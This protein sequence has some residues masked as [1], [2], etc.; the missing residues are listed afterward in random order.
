M[1]A[2]RF[3][4]PGE[5]GMERVIAESGRAFTE[6]GHRVTVL[7]SALE[8]DGAGEFDVGGLRVIRHAPAP[9]GP[10]KTLCRTGLTVRIA[11]EHFRRLAGET[12]LVIAKH[13]WYAA[14]AAGALDAPI[15]FAPEVLSSAMMRAHRRRAA[16][17]WRERL[18]F[19]CRATA[20]RRTER[21]ALA[22]ARAVVQPTEITRQ[23]WIDTYGDAAAN[24][25]VIPNGVD[26]RLFCPGGP[27]ASLRRELGLS[28]GDRMILLAARLTDE[29]DP[30]FL[31]EALAEVREKRA[32]LVIAGDGYLAGAIRRRAAE[33]HLAD[34]VILAG[35]R[36]DIVRFY[37]T[38]D[39]LVLPSRYEAFGNVQLEAMACGLPVVARASG[40]DVRT[41]A[42]EIVAHGVT[43]L[44]TDAHDPKH[45]AAAIDMIL[46][47]RA[48][49]ATMRTAARTRALRLFSWPDHVRRMLAA[50]GM[51]TAAPA[52]PALAWHAA[53]RPAARNATPQQGGIH[54]P[55]HATIP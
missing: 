39:L 34:R 22:V 35:M 41:P 14:A 28:A 24:I 1:I 12:D 4:Y 49:A 13:P 46:S 37:R 17:C 48:L 19:A 11:A 21:I 52:G 36:A 26:H 7:C 3:F 10:V 40:G 5:G 47:D 20:T 25:R 42:A 38:A 44:C 6:A 51:E 33:L 31:L 8:A 54:D 43:G 55:A 2:Y 30:M 32:K 29:K 50:V 53:E 27:D 18:A 45:M 9:F 23:E 16:R 15:L